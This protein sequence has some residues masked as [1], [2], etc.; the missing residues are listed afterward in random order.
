MPVT[1]TT[2]TTYLPANRLANFEVSQDVDGGDL[3]GR[4]ELAVVVQIEIDLP[5]AQP[6]FADVALAVAVGVGVVERSRRRV[7]RRPRSRRPAGGRSCPTPATPRPAWA[8]RRGRCAAV[9]RSLV[10]GH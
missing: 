6:G 5:Q 1:G 9:N 3:V 7:A 4:V 2:R 10:S 8:R